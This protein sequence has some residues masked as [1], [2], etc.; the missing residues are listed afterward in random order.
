MVDSIVRLLRD[1]NLLNG[2]M[3]L[4]DCC[5]GTGS[6]SYAVCD[7]VRVKLNDNLL[8]SG[9]YALGRLVEWYCKFD[10][11]GFDPFEYLNASRT[12]YDG[13]VSRNYAPTYSG[14]MYFSDFNAGRIDYFRK[15]IE[16][17]H[18]GG[19]ITENEY[20]YLLSS[21]VESVSKVANVAGVYGS[22]L[23]VWDPRAVKEIRFISPDK[24][25]SIQTTMFEKKPL[26]EPVLYNRNIEDLIS[27][28]ECDI[29]YLDPPYTN[30]SY[31]VQYH[32]LE[33]IVRDDRPLLKGVTGARQYE[34]ISN[35]WSKNYQAG[36]AFDKIVHMTKAEHIVFSYSSD[37]LMSCDLILNTLKRYC[38]PDSIE[39]RKIP[40]K[41]YQNSR[42]GEVIEHYEYLFYGRKK[43]MD[44][45]VYCC[46]LNYMGGKSNVISEIRPYLN[47]K[48]RFFD[49]MGGGFNVGANVLG[50]N[51]VVY[52]DINSKVVGLVKMFRDIP[53]QD[54]LRSLDIIVKKYGLE[55]QAKEPYIKLRNDYN[56]KYRGTEQEYIYLYATIL[57]GFQ[58]QIRFNSSLEYNNPVGESG[59]NDCIKEKIISFS[60]RIKSIDVTFYEGDYSSL[61]REI[62]AECLVYV[63]PPYLITLG[64]YN[65]GKR[66][67]N[68]WTESEEIRLLTFLDEIL[69]KGAK[70]V[71]SNI[72]E[73][74][75]CE[76]SYLK[77][78]IE[79]RHPVVRNICVRGRNEVLIIIN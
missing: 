62:D 35:V 72:L 24:Q 41:K 63:D 70:V 67:F 21:L 13:F 74:K 52:N 25:T 71:M 46:P 59:Y 29:L 55:K 11:L 66:G 27:D 40:Y 57:Y 51:E 34:N 10:Q 48:R 76:N 28:V 17:W 32:L 65:D 64:S 4:F 53:T 19:K 77:D 56:H 14:R 58:Q 22:Y 9:V 79:Q 60:R 7:Q 30:N 37:G 18:A 75:G 2:D 5:C 54:I 44:Q 20:V 26:A 50:F 36:I 38:F 45:V 39:L 8:S 61:I 16:D 6:V 47:G 42:T 23:K 3:T 69:G 49:I 1:K 33:T 12:V 68:G 15:Q 78:W 43:P 73:Y 31:S